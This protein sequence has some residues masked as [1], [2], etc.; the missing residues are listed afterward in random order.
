MTGKKSKCHIAKTS[1]SAHMPSPR[2][3][4]NQTHNQRD[5]AE[6]WIITIFGNGLFFKTSISFY[7]T[8]NLSFAPTHSPFLS[9]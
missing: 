9:S 6:I 4:S 2:Q 3:M 7:P 8:R 1:A 5:A